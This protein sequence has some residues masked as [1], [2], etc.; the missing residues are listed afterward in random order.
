MER[1]YV[2]QNKRGLY[3]IMTKSELAFLLVSY[4]DKHKYRYS[5]ISGHK[6]LAYLEGATLYMGDVYSNKDRPDQWND[7]RIVL[8]FS[9]NKIPYISHIAR[10]T[11]E[12][13]TSATHSGNAAKNGGVARLQLT[14]YKG[15]AKMGFHKVKTHPALVQ[16]GT[17]LVHRDKN[18]DQ[19]RTGDPIHPATGI[20][21][22]G[23]NPEFEGEKVSMWSEGCCVGWSWAK[24]VEF[25]MLMKEDSRY[26]GNKSF[27]WDFT[28]IDFEKLK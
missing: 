12:P 6:N 3:N 15:A 9:A 19:K 27:A 11:C 17:I 24:H 22:H 2:L 16:V 28:L 13:G 21:H 14:Q 8:E 26:I 5:Q 7:L 10:A 1:R 20:N 18:K 25:I 23:T 4:F